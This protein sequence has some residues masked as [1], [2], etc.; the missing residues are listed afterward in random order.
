MALRPVGKGR[1]TPMSRPRNC[2]PE[3]KPSP[4]GSP[5]GGSGAAAGKRSRR[6]SD[7]SRKARAVAYVRESTEEQGKGFSPDAQREAIRR[8]ADE[9]ELELVDDYTDFHSGWKHADARTEFQRLMTDAAERRFEVVLVYH[10]SRFARN[11]SEARRYKALLR[12]RL[13]IR[14]VSVTQPIGDDPSDPSFFLAESI[15]EMFDEY[16]SVSLSFWTRT[17]LREKAR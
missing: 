8:F 15:H 4:A 5:T 13:G 7:E 11:Q 17:G 1:R 10:T 2:T 12:D 16:Y 3:S 14:V 9:N 6:N